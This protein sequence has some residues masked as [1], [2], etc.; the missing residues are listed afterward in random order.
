MD[1]QQRTGRLR[2]LMVE[3]ALQYSP[4]SSI[5]PF[6]PETIP[7]PTPVISGSTSL[8]SNL[9]ERAAS[10][11]AI[12]DLKAEA[13]R[14]SGKSELVATAVSNVSSLL[15]S[16]ALTEFKF[17]SIPGVTDKRQQ[18]LK[19][20]GTSNAHSTPQQTGSFA[21][22]VLR[23]SDVRYTR[24]TQVST[25]LRSAQPQANSKVY[26][27]PPASSTPEFKP[28]ASTK[29]AHAADSKHVHQKD[30]VIK[31]SG[32]PVPTVIVPPI[33][34]ERSREYERFPDED[35]RI[36][37]SELSK[38]LARKRK[39][40]EMERDDNQI[41]RR[42]DQKEKSEISLRDLQDLVSNIFEAEDQLQ[43][44]TSGAVSV[45]ASNYF[46]SA[47]F[48]DG[49]I[50]TLASSIQTKLEAS[51]QKVISM[52]V[53]AHIPVDQLNR[54]QK[55][56]E[57]A[58]A[59]IEST[60]LRVAEIQSDDDVDSWLQRVGLAENALKAA[61]T[62][63]RI[64]TGGREE[65]QLYSEEQLQ[66]ILN[67]LKTVFDTCLIPIVELRNSGPNGDMFKKLSAQRKAISTLLH[68][69]GKVLRLLADLLIKVEVSEGAVTTVEFLAS[70]LIFVENAP[71]EKESVLGIQKYETLR[72]TGMD[73]LGKIFA[74]Y[75]DQRTFIIDEIL[76]SLEK[77][78]VTRQN[79]RHYKLVEGKNIQLVS[80]LIMLLIQS[81]GTIFPDAKSQK[82]RAAAE[83]ANGE[84]QD[85]ADLSEEEEDYVR[86]V[87]H[88]PGPPANDNETTAAQNPQVAIR[89]L[90]DLVRPLYENAHSI[91]SYVI[92]YLVQ[93]AQTSTKTGD[94]PYRHLL[95]IFTEDFVTVIDSADW[96]AAELLLRILLI[97]TINIAESDKSTAPAKN[98]AL[99]LMGLMGST[100][101]DVMLFVRQLARNLENDESEL[102]G[103]LVQLAED[104]L[105]GKISGDELLLWEGVYRISVQYLDGRNIGDAVLQSACGYCITQWARGV[106]CSFEAMEDD[107]SND[108]DYGRLSYRI[109]KMAEDHN[110]LETE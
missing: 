90:T 98:M 76:T 66:N 91:A 36:N 5:A 28:P 62:V 95:D 11:G 34:A 93:R 110:W 9:G 1:L 77:L 65:K 20:N 35:L 107:E 103:Y 60:D 19:T 102:S 88:K 46:M 33:S 54:L 12:D 49:N 80:A 108:I 39:R 73:V 79:A 18:P 17:K 42:A 26:R 32:K 83:L 2:P 3:E 27:D 97:T 56:S 37:E 61:R 104:S 6:S 29:Q 22:M 96:P 106:W 4:L 99:D 15:R 55:L 45:D 105:S 52:G 58:L 43:P 24:P 8:V 38:T 67:M 81:C 47:G 40:E 75:P 57:G 85:P 51:I 92:K 78:P 23:S 87:S 13:R 53:F 82:K 89:D 72:R 50:P 16:E 48:S 100:I 69:C 94:Q 31:A 101:S 30:S 41:S 59:L 109:R 21:D 10:R 71:S 63:L 44:D 64:M 25:D 84:E 7:L 86:D 68:H 14:T 70:T 74:R